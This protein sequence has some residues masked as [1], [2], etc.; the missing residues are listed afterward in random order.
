MKAHFGKY[1][2]NAVSRKIKI[3]IDDHDIWSFDHTLANIILPGLLYYRQAAISI[4]NNVINDSPTNRS[5]GDKQQCFEFYK[6]SDDDIENMQLKEW[7]DIL[8]KMIWSFHQILSCDID[9]QYSH[10]KANFAWVPAPESA[11]YSSEEELFIL[12]DNST[13]YWVDFDGIKLHN[14]RIQ[15]G[16]TLFGKH[17]R[18]LWR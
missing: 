2:K 10:G 17:F 9:E 16:L 18:D 5:T 8:D 1:S 3:Q 7:H 4:P 14:E 12:Q 15:E 6:I 13:D 11:S